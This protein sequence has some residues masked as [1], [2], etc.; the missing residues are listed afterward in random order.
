MRK[1][2]RH[3]AVIGGG[4]GDLAIALA[5]AFPDDVVA[6]FDVDPQAVANARRQAARAG[7]A[8]RVTFEATGPGSLLGSGYHL[9]VLT[10]PPW[11]G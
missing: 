11:R 10:S 4:Q 6:G 5:T 2:R 3:I 7:V 1:P 9:V 8:D